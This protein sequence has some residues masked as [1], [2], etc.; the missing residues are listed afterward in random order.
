MKLTCV[1]SWWN[2]VTDGQKCAVVRC[3][4][5]PGCQIFVNRISTPKCF[6]DYGIFYWLFQSS[7]ILGSA[8]IIIEC[9]YPDTATTF[10][11]NPASLPWNCSVSA[12]HVLKGGLMRLFSCIE[13]C[14]LLFEPLERIAIILIVTSIV[15][16]WFLFYYRQKK[17]SLSE[18]DSLSSLPTYAFQN[19]VKEWNY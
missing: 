2:L 19:E 8:I 9:R 12:A 10:V 13:D 15:N 18:M 16:Y 4:I 6:L 3:R 7:H 14:F 1:N 17:H 5:F 11:Y